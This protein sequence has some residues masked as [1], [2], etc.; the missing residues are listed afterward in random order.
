MA[1][2]FTSHKVYCTKSAKIVWLGHMKEQTTKNAKKNSKSK[3]GDED[4][5]LE[6]VDSLRAGE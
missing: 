1:A 6:G 3:K 5:G 2:F 4:Q